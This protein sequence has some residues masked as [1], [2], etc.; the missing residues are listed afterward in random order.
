MRAIPTVG[1][2]L[3]YLRVALIARRL[4]LVI[5]L[6]HGRGP[7][8]RNGRERRTLERMQRTIVRDGWFN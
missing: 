6:K 1:W 5:A 2:Q 7:G 3:P 4:D 8:R